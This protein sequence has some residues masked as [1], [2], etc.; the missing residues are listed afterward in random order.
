MLAAIRRAIAR[1]QTGGRA[2][3]GLI[4]AIDEGERRAVVVT[5]NEGR[6]VDFFDVPRSREAATPTVFGLITAATSNA[7]PGTAPY[8]SADVESH[9]SWC[10]GGMSV[11]D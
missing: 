4:L 8:R 1:E 6:L 7:F 11:A 2:P 10:S 9:T 3:A 5:N